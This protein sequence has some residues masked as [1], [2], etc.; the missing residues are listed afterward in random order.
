MGS[1]EQMGNS[2]KLC[3]QTAGS[4]GAF[5]LRMECILEAGYRC[6]GAWAWGL[7]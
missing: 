3:G 5:E 2:N 6:I 7:R 1:L 4:K